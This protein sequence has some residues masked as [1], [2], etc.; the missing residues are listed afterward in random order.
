MPRTDETLRPSSHYCA[1][2]LGPLPGMYALCLTDVAQKLN[3]VAGEAIFTVVES[4]SRN[5]KP[6]F[7]VEFPDTFTQLQARRATLLLVGKANT[8]YPSRPPKSL[9]ALGEVT[10]AQI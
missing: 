4:L 1:V 8:L 9:R 5:G 6:R 2:D 10:L 7:S 3:S